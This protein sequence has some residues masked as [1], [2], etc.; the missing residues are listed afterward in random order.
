[1][2]ID[3]YG[4]VQHVMMCV[5]QQYGSPLRWVNAQNAEELQSLYGRDTEGAYYRQRFD[6]IMKTVQ[7]DVMKMM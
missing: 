2:N 3:E 7:I 5:L 4:S 1:M 6:E